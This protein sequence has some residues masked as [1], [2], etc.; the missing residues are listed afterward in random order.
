MSYGYSKVAH[1]SVVGNVEGK[2]YR[3][4][5]IMYE[6]LVA[7]LSTKHNYSQKMLTSHSCVQ[8]YLELDK[9]N[10]IARLTVNS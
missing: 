8:K 10:S 1:H 2:H 6:N 9:D 7:T 5:Q 3:I 4:K